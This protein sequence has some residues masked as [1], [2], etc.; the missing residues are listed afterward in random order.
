[1]GVRR[2]GEFTSSYSDEQLYRLIRRVASATEADADALSQPL[3]D[4]H[5]PT[6]AVDLELPPPPTA[7]AIYMRFKKKRGDISWRKIV[8]AAL[9]AV[10]VSQQ[11]AVDN[12]ADEVGEWLDERGIVFA[13][14]RVASAT[15]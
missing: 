9:G 7:R 11:V 13:L 5:A 14:R 2:R 3:F 6:A 10:N 15:G 8:T 1:M 4:K 12:S